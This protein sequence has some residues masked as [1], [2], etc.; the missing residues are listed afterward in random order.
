MSEL[1][2]HGV[3]SK[4][5]LRDAE[6]Y[7]LEEEVFGGSSAQ[8]VVNSKRSFLGA[9]ASGGGVMYNECGLYY[10]NSNHGKRSYYVESDGDID[11]DRLN[12]I[13]SC[14]SGKMYGANIDDSNFG[15][16]ETK[17]SYVYSQESHAFDQIVHV[18]KNKDNETVACSISLFM[19][20]ISASG[21]KI[22]LAYLF[23]TNDPLAMDNFNCFRGSA[24]QAEKPGIKCVEQLVFC[25]AKVLLGITMAESMDISKF[26]NFVMEGD[27]VSFNTIVE[28]LNDDALKKDIRALKET[29][30][31]QGK[32]NERLLNEKCLEKS[33]EYLKDVDPSMFREKY[34][35]WVGRFLSQGHDLPPLKNYKFV[36]RSVFA[37]GDYLKTWD[38]I[39]LM[40][41]IS[42]R[43]HNL[44]QS[45]Q[46]RS[47]VASMIP[48][49]VI[50]CSK[51]D[52]IWGYRLSQGKTERRLGWLTKEE[53]GG[54]DHMMKIVED[55]VKF[56]D[57][58]I[59]E[60][61]SLCA[62]NNI[63]AALRLL[64]SPDHIN[65][66]RFQVDSIHKLGLSE[67]IIQSIWT[68]QVKFPLALIARIRSRLDKYG[69]QFHYFDPVL[70][71]SKS[72][73]YDVASSIGY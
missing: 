2:S 24:A 38:S 19:P 6:L 51:D 67:R 17:F 63:N 39:S 46:E 64:F 47:L 22:F 73:A 65:C 26:F 66:G 4:Q 30:A 5:R 1:G 13:Q 53:D 25:E 23:T 18:T 8:Q 41:A 45:K 40:C 12:S 58:F 27:P 14:L 71:Q 42:A 9:V 54:R 68:G 35:T 48:R 21:E 44:E 16:Q 11:T 10:L 33:R 57:S 72:T 59:E 69:I 29:A 15:R 3:N 62:T 55:A 28:V 52:N 70:M 34:I 49:C 50:E 20:D 43:M 36:G 60:L 56:Q 7:A 61:A 37:V 31:Y 32:E